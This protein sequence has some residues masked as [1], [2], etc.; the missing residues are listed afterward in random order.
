MNAKTIIATIALTLGAAPGFALAAGAMNDTTQSMS[1]IEVR[2]DMAAAEATE[3]YSTVVPVSTYSRAAVV[4]DLRIAQ[5]TG[6]RSNLGETFGSFRAGQIM[7]NNVQAT[8]LADAKTGLS[9]RSRDNYL[10][11]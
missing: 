2:Q 4:A 7:S 8:V 1:R 9:A 10:G 6:L 5:A 11:A 3:A